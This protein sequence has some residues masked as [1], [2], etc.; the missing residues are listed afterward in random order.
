M[1]KTEEDWKDLKTVKPN[2][3][4]KL[5]LLLAT[6]KNI[7]AQ[8]TNFFCHGSL[9]LLFT[10]NLFAYFKFHSDWGRVIGKIKQNELDCR[11]TAPLIMSQACQWSLL[12]TPPCSDHVLAKWLLN[13]LALSSH[14]KVLKMHAFSDENQ[15]EHDYWKPSTL[16]RKSQLTNHAEGRSKTG[17]SR[18]RIERIV[19][20]R[21]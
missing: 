2:R 15:Q 17:R 12:H 3:F 4:S 8:E 1:G 14:K 19:E 18:R 7:N 5:I 20:Q 11:D 6:S 16:R 21:K 10:C 9:T 13:F